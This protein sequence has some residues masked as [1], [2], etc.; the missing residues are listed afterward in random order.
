MLTSSRTYVIGFA[1]STLLTLAAF[2]LVFQYIAGS[3]PIAREW[4]IVAL[5]VFAVAQLIVQVTC[6]LHLGSETKPRW[7]L[8]TFLFSLLVV[9]ILV[10]GSIWI[11]THLTHNM[12]QDTSHVW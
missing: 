12:M 7:Q 8:I 4:L 1:L 10:G 3:L 6:F 9:V 2:G 5:L 11:M